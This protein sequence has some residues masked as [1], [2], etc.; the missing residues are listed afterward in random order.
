MLSNKGQMK[1]DD[2]RILWTSDPIVSDAIAMRPDVNPAFTEK[3]RDAYL[4]LA[5]ED[6]VV[7][8]QFMSLFNLKSDSLGYVSAQDSMY[9]G[10]RRIAASVKDLKAV[11]N[12]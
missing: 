11:G 9:D 4:H 5:E 7:W 6:P 2:V 3:V 8:K 1:P 12:K 10:L